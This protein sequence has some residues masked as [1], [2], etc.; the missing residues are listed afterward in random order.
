L[1]EKRH[2]SLCRRILT[3][4]L[5]IP[6]YTEA[7]QA[8]QQMPQAGGQLAFL[9]R[10]MQAAGVQPNPQQVQQMLAQIQGEGQSLT[11]DLQALAAFFAARDAPLASQVLMPQQQAALVGRLNW[12]PAKHPVGHGGLFRLLAE[13]LRK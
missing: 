7:R 2:A 8:A 12:W 6:A 3:V 5:I 9:A 1:S 10:Q 13:R 11:Q 4:S